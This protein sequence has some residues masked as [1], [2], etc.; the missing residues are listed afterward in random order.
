MARPLSAGGYGLIV[1]DGVAQP[2][3]RPKDVD[4]VVSARMARVRGRDI[5]LNSASGLSCIAGACGTG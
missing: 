3:D 4:P 1:G 2:I 5:R